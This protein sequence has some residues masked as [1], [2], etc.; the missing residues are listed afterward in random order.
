MGIFD[1]LFG[2]KKKDQG[3]MVFREGEECKTLAVIIDGRTI[4][5]HGD[6]V[7]ILRAMPARPGHPYNGY[8]VYSPLI[9]SRVEL[10]EEELFL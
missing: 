9:R 5:N 10:R 3:L 1:K 7:R 4:F 8:I 6:E 2:G